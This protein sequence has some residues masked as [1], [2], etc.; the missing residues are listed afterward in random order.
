MGSRKDE[1]PAP[2]D[3][4][5]GEAQPV[6][7]E[8]MKE[9]GPDLFVQMQK[10]QTVRVVFLGWLT[11]G[12]YADQPMFCNPKGAFRCF[13]LPPHEILMD[14]CKSVDMMT[15]CQLTCEGQRREGS[16]AFRY[17]LGVYPRITDETVLAKLADARR[18]FLAKVAELRGDSVPSRAD[19]DDLPF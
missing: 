14:L 10:G 12:K 2:A 7:T 18:D 11:G 3:V 1:A 6:V 8:T 9:R 15:P 13:A 4:F 19:D 5:A 17:T 16:G